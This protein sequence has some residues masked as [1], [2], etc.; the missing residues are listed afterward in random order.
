MY[1]RDKEG[2]LSA[3]DALSATCGAILLLAPWMAASSSHA[4]IWNGCLIGAAV[5]GLTLHAFM[6]R[7]HADRWALV[8]LGVWSAAAPWLLRFTHDAHAKE[9]HIGLGVLVTVLAATA[10]W[11]QNEAPDNKAA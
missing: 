9:M 1:A 2:P 6:T 7:E 4:A 8:I 3:I 5:L 10:L 11:I